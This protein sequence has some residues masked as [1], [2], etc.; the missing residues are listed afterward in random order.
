MRKH[1]MLLTLLLAMLV[2]VLA[3]ATETPP[4]EVLALNGEADRLI[5]YLSFL[6]PDGSTVSFCLD[7]GGFMDGYRCEN[8]EWSIHSQVSPVDGTWDAQMVRHDTA[9]VHADG[10]HYQDDLGFDILCRKTGNR[11]SY[12]YN[13]SE[14]VLCGW[15]NPSAYAGTVLLHG[16]TASFYPTGASQ[17]EGSYRLGE[18]SDSL[19][20]SF[21]DLPFTPAQAQAMAAITEAAVADRYPGYTLRYYESYNANA[22]A[23]AC[24]SRIENGLLHVKR[25]GFS[26]ENAPAEADCMPVPLSPVLLEK[27]EAEPFDQL[28]NISGQ[29]SLFDTEAA[30]DT[31][32]IPVSGRIVESDLQSCGLLLLVE[33]VQGTRRLQLISREDGSYRSR[34]TRPLPAGAWLDVFHAGEGEVFVCWMEEA[35]GKPLECYASF[36]VAADGTWQL[37]YITHGWQDDTGYSLCHC[38]PRLEYSVCSSNG[39]M[40]GTLP[41]S[42]LFS[43]DLP[44]LPTVDRLAS[45]L[46]RSGW[47][48]VNNPDPADRLHLRTQPD[49][50]AES[51]GRF[52]N[53][54]PVQVLEQQGEWC[55]VQIGV[56]GRLTGWMM[57]EYLAFGDQMDAV[58][59]AFP[60]QVLLGQY[61]GQ[62]LYASKKLDDRTMLEGELW[63]VG[64]A[65][66]G[67]YVLLTPD[68]GT[69]YAPIS[70]FFE[71]NG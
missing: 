64:L 16:L 60:E 66:G 24:Y 10:S 59:C 42:E 8:G 47:A 58:D 9:A 21:E 30:V 54:T 18:F 68:G 65:D 25:V 45:E 31:D 19:L 36:A 41:G 6:L 37:G 51:L 70:W 40:V 44:A 63:V 52:Y 12:H 28:L 1:L 67:L 13:G 2:P 53:G 11:L 56:D 33:D 50:A 27:L 55:R 22:A 61:E 26:W 4:P 38:G 34:S 3:T 71:G 39:I 35:D 49:R 20:M 43:V 48:K 62:P 57:K 32:Q 23:Y 29:T 7:Q 14:F 5:G 46:D 69:A 17:P 15:E